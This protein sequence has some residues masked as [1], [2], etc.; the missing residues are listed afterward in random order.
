MEYRYLIVGGGMTGGAAVKGIRSRDTEGSIALVG[1]ESHPPYARPP[2][3]K[4]LWKGKDEDSIWRGTEEQ[5]IDLKL[6]RRITSLDLDAKRAT[7]DRGETYDYERLLF[8]TGG[9]P[10]QLA[11]AAD[12]VIYFRT[13]DDYRRLREAAAEGERARRDRGRFHRL[14]ARR[15]PR[16]ERREGDVALPG[17]G[18]RQ[19]PLPG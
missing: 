9:K 15:R 16:V 18:D 12:G 14:R 1:E 6:G 5:D 8:A 19:P 11:N 10:R 3:S 17:P 4:A 7:D 2:L 13:L